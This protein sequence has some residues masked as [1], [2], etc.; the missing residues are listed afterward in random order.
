MWYNKRGNKGGN[1]M[2]DT[3]DHGPAPYVVDIEKLT[4]DNPNFRTT[5]WTGGHIQLTVMTIPVGGDIGLEV[6]PDNDQFL[7]IEQGRGKVEMGPAEDN[8]DFVRE[9][10]D[11]DAVFVPAGTW[12]NITNVGEEDLK[13]YTVYCPRDHV[14]GTVHAT[15]ADAMSDPNEQ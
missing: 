8:L 15:Q 2:I 11:D 14:P 7:R 13:L 9:V 10:A 6:H 12:H 4:L 1:N 3:T 5:V